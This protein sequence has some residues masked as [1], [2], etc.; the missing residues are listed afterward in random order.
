MSERGDEGRAGEGAPPPEWL[1]RREFPF[2]S[3]WWQTEVGRMH[4]IDEGE[5]PPIVFVHGVPAWSFNVRV[6]VRGLSSRYRCVA[7]DHLGFG[8]SDKP[9][10]W[11]YDPA[12]LATH[13]EAWIV[14]LGLGKVTLVVHDW[15]GPLGL[16]YALRHPENVAR[17]VLMNSWMWSSEGDLRARLMARFLASPPYMALEDR[18]A[19][20]ARLFT[21]LAVARRDQIHPGLFAHFGAPF[22]RREDRAGLRALVRAI[23]GSDKWVGSLWKE[24]EQIRD[25][26]TLILWGMKDP[27]FP[28]RYLARWETLFTRARIERLVGVGHYP[29]EE[30]PEEVLRMIEAFLAGEEP[31]S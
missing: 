24:R 16:A 3:R 6:L 27:A 4:Y 10:G 21:R 13:L 9:T 20:T 14:G 18:I 31:T 12:A 11:H 15:G 8:L 17:L 23:H 22:R 25:L 28:P 29:H 2:P 5:G 19:V 7:A 26:P 1:D 30:A